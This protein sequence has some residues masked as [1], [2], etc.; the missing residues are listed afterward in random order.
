MGF[1]KPICVA[2]LLSLLFF[3]CDED[4]Q[5]PPSS[6]LDYFPLQTGLYW[7]YEVEE[8]TNLQG[9]ENSEVYELEYK[10]TD[11]IPGS[12][13]LAVFII[14]RSIRGNPADAWTILDTWSS[15]ANSIEG[16]MQEGNIDFVKMSFPLSKGKSWDGNAYNTFG[17]SESC[18]SEEYACDLYSI[19]AYATP[20]TA[21][22]SSGSEIYTDAIVIEQ[23]NITDLIVAQDI[24][25]EVYA[26][27]V[28]LIY[29]ESVQIEYCTVGSCLGQQVVDKGSWYYQRLIDYGC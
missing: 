23:S 1:K 10:I 4:A 18:G 2:A 22:T 17:G 25:T 20:Y 21:T 27:N 9:T 26:R 28:G 7:V 12:D 3:S 24:R 16:I 5:I 19:T 15:R 8:T 11:S 29:K 6:D 13:K 14:T